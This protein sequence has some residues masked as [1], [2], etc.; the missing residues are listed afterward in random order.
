MNLIFEKK[1]HSE[2]PV[3]SS[4]VNI[5]SRFQILNNQFCIWN[6]KF[7]KFSPFF[8]MNFGPNS[9]LIFWNLNWN[10]V[11]ISDT[12]VLFSFFFPVYHCPGNCFFRLTTLSENVRFCSVLPTKYL[13]SRIF[14]I[15]ICQLENLISGHLHT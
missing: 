14:M 6:C 5:D 10:K 2:I 3:S 15:F 1:S 7:P 4:F 8:A 11:P 12:F 9:K 13:H